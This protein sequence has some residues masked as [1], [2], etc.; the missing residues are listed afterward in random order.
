LRSREAEQGDG[1]GEE[2]EEEIEGSFYFS[3]AGLTKM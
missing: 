1:R 3:R 2:I